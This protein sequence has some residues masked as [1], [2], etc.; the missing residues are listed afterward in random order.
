V[1]SP[2]RKSHTFILSLLERERRNYPAAHAKQAPYLR[3][4]DEGERW[5]VAKQ[6]CH[7]VYRKG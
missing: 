1:V 5:I 6:K 3:G 7:H 2:R 4:K